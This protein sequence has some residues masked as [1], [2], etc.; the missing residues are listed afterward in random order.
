M[1]SSF[2]CKFT[3]PPTKNMYQYKTYKDTTFLCVRLA[4]IINEIPGVNVHFKFPFC[5][6]IIYSHV[7]SCVKFM[8]SVKS[9]RNVCTLAFVFNPVFVTFYGIW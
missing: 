3:R 6:M 4:I 2:G 9:D 7:P 8:F 1:F 5:F